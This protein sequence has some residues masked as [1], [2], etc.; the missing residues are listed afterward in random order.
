MKLCNK[1]IIA[2]KLKNHDVKSLTKLWKDK[3]ENNQT[4]R[5]SAN[6]ENTIIVLKY[7]TD[8]IGKLIINIIFQE[9][10]QLFELEVL[11]LFT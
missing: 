6:N 5:N 4:K 1:I 10:I 8:D 9:L 7:Q 11:Q 2:H 3:T